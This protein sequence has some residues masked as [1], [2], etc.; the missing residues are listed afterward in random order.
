MT[1]TVLEDKLCLL[2]TRSETETSAEATWNL[3]R[4]ESR[5]PNSSIQYG[6]YTRQTIR[7]DD[8]H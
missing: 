2:A 3:I 4:V 7:P 8:S 1:A 5:H 6:N